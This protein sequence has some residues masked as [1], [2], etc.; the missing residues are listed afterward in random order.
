[1]P[2][3]MKMEKTRSYNAHAAP[4]KR[5]Y[6]KKIADIY[7]RNLRTTLYAGVRSI[8]LSFFVLNFQYQQHF[9]INCTRSVN[10]LRPIIIRKRKFIK[11]D[12]DRAMAGHT[13]KNLC[14]VDI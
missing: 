5:K 7:A 11:G 9:T 3:Q 2:L 13:L 12:R 10:L 4:G 8:V 14:C 6:A 1:M